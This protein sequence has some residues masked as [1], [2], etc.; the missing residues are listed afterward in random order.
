MQSKEKKD[1]KIQIDPYVM[2]FVECAKFKH[3][4]IDE[5]LAIV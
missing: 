1:Q 2:E 3:V 4:H 5:G